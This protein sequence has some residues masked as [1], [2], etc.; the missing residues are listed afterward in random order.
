MD[1]LNN[2]L[3]GIYRHLHCHPELSGR[4]TNTQ[5]FLLDALEQMGIETQT[6]PGQNAVVALIRG[7]QS[8]KCVALRADMDALPI[9]EKTGADITSQTP[10]VMHACGHDAHMTIALGA[11]KLLHEAR[12][13]LRGTVKIFFEPEEETRGGGKSMVAAGCLLHPKVDAVL[14]L[15]MNPDFDTGVIYSKPE[16]VSGSSTD[17][18]ITVTGKACHGAYPERGVD[19]VVIAAQIVLALQTLVSRNLSP[20]DSAALSI[21]QIQGGI[22]SNIMCEEVILHGTLRTLSPQTQAFMR[23]R[24]EEA[25]KGIAQAHGGGAEAA[26]KDGYQSLYND[27]ELHRLLEKRAENLIIRKAPSLG[28]ESFSFF[29]ENTPGLYYDLGSGKGTPLHTD[30]FQVDERVLLIGAKL[31]AQLAMDYLNG[32][33]AS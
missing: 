18:L 19:A 31:Q 24:I 1:S 33:D 10:G 26:F 9:T 23:R 15:H 16:Y 30:T 12:Q 20:F 13:D 7:G 25:A 28:V 8:G 2:W 29:I 14:G 5:A 4:E 11:A 6:Y 21:G 27:P 22:A 32:G 17:V 3:V